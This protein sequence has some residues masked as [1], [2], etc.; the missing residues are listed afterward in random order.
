MVR[1]RVP[2][3]ELKKEI[4]NNR[5]L[6][7]NSELEVR[8]ELTTLRVLVWTLYWRLYG[9]QGRKL[10]INRP[11]VFLNWVDSLAWF[12]C[13]LQVLPRYSLRV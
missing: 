8:I 3:H 6:R 9:E 4:T 7:K 10:I 2:M 5:K 13:S 12:F 1:L 11:V